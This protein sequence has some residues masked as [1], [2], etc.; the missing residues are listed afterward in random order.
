MNKQITTPGL[1]GLGPTEWQTELLPE[2]KGGATKN[3]LIDLDVIKAKQ[4]ISRLRGL[5]QME[6][7]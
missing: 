3:P 2:F 5:G 1:P 4:A 7:D 6:L